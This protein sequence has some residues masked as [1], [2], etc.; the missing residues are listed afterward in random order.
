MIRAAVLTISDSS[1]MGV[2]ADESGCVLKALVT[3]LPG[4][5]EEA[6]IVAD[7]IEQIQ[8]RLRHYVDELG[9]DLVV[10]TGGTGISPRDVTPEATQPLLEK[11]LPGLPEAMRAAGMR[12]TPYAMLT[13]GVAGI[14]GACI[15]VNF[16]GSPRAVQEN[17]EAVRPVLKHMI[18]KC[19]GDMRP[20]AHIEVASDGQ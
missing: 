1:S 4:H 13:R 5:V 18:E 8:E 11:E 3:A 20:C 2:R 17:F 16:P 6:D 9:L 10:T 19:Q 7:E 14:R 15:I 12:K